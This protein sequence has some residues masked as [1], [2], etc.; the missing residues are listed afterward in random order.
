MSSNIFR[1]CPTI[2]LVKST[3]NILVICLHTQHSLAM[4][5]KMSTETPGVLLASLTKQIEYKR[6]VTSNQQCEATLG[7]IFLTCNFDKLCWV[8]IGVQPPRPRT[9]CL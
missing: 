6:Y 3:S 2:L 5:F 1:D 7:H 8:L 9:R 4:G